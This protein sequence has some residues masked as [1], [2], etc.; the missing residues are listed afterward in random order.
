MHRQLFD[1][2]VGIMQPLYYHYP[3]LDNAYRMTA[4]QNAQYFFG[5]DIMVAPITA[6]AEG[7]NG[8]PTQKLATK[9]VWMPPGEWY[10]GLTG[11]V[12]AVTF[13]QGELSSR[14][15][16]LGE[17]PMWYKA[18]SVVPYVP[19]RSMPSLTGV[20]SQQ[21]HFL[22]FRIMP[23][24]I[25]DSA[26]GM[27]YEDDGTTT[28]YL[29]G[30]HVKTVCNVRISPTSHQA[31]VDIETLGIEHAHSTF[32]K[33]RAYQLRFPN[34]LPPQNVTLNFP[35]SGKPESVPFVR[36]GAVASSRRVPPSSQWYY[37][38]EED[39][40]LNVVIDLVGVPTNSAV[41]VIIE[42]K[43]DH[44]TTEALNAGLYG[45][46]MRAVLAHANQDVDRTNPDENSPGPAYLSQLSSV[47]VALEKLAD[48]ESPEGAFATLVAEV[49]ELLSKAM[50]ELQD[51]KKPNGRVEYTLALL[52]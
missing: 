43:P 9:Q 41:S 17:V 8:D 49:P 47:G 34:A 35:G 32:P 42:N 20:A 27:V 19:L 2:G 1:S 45:T 12:L 21:N 15:Y 18:S 11:E 38:F 4:S 6:P 29:D 52:R 23:T 44:A 30:T 7:G 25:T 16:T 31:L 50:K 36:F 46:L 33:R 26:V 13:D 28:A 51:I 14:G 3:A 40:G 22:G 5:N 10:D 24:A 48:P 37:A 39:E